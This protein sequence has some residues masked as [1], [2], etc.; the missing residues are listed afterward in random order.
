MSTPPVADRLIDAGELGRVLGL[1]RE[2]VLTLAREGK[3][4]SLRISRK[5]IR[6]EIRAVL[7]AMKA[8]PRG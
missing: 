5:V 1:H 4:P 3:I 2:T 8:P 7:E 6:F